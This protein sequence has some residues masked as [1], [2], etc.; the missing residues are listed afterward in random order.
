MES[1][2]FFM[3]RLP[4]L[5]ALPGM[6][7]DHRM[8]PTPWDSLPGF[9]ARDWPRHQGEAS[10]PELADRLIDEF[11]MQPGDG[12][13]GASL[14]GMVGCEIARR[15]PLRHL[16]LIG[17]A[18]HPTEVRAPL[19]MVH[20]IAAITPFRPLVRLAARIP[21]RLTEGFGASEPSFIRAM[22]SAVFTWRGCPVQMPT[23]LRI[24]G[25]F[26]WIIRP[27]PN[28][29]LL[30]SGGHFISITHARDCVEFIRPRLS[31]QER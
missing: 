14:G 12:I 7:A 28:A 27:P 18:E 8:F 16:I 20:P 23:P 10:L 22:C 30:L 29:D 3:P 21:A 4:Q 1:R 2:P 6:G 17:S 19:R 9:I 15:V 25:R 11:G 24:H 13:V 26:D 31:D 5:H